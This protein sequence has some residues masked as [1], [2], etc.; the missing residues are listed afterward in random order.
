M[1]RN[2]TAQIFRVLLPAKDL[3]VAKRFY[4]FLLGSRGRNV[5]GGRI[6]F[7]CGPVILGL[8]DSSSVV[9]ERRPHFPE[10][11]Y[12]A[13]N[14]LT[15]LHRR[16]AK[17]ACLDTGL[18]HGDPDNPAGEIV[19]RP[20]GE[21]SFYAHDPTGNSLCFVSAR[22]KFTGTTRQISALRRAEARVR[23]RRSSTRSARPK[24]RRRTPRVVGAR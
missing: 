9:E 5:A 14:D 15:E 16:A 10:A 19:V 23:G 21:L 18:L 1:K 17:L 6:Y 13:T 24:A 11:I 7:D 4:E 12:L 22:T 2:A 8:L 20:W 3:A